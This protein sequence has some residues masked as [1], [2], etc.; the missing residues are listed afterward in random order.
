[1][2]IN[3]RMLRILMQYS[4]YAA[5]VQPEHFVCSINAFT[6]STHFGNCESYPLLK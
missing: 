6:V 1:M 2:C 5:E 4:K 3:Q